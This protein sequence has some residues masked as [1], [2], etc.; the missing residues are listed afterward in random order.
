M[1]IC[2]LLL[3][4]HIYIFT[5]DFRFLLQNYFTHFNITLQR[6]GQ[7]VNCYIY[8]FYWCDRLVTFLQ[9]GLSLGGRSV[10]V[11]RWV[12]SVGLDGRATVKVAKC[13]RHAAPLIAVCLVIAYVQR[14]GKIW[15]LVVR[16][17]TWSQFSVGLPSD[18]TCA[19]FYYVN[20]N[21]IYICII[22]GLGSAQYKVNYWTLPCVNH[23]SHHNYNR[24]IN[25]N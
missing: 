14:A 9:T 1:Y 10:A 4:R 25:I 15:V 2:C 5:G 16:E 21:D 19:I 7:P 8:M 17:T 13:T 24:E 12:S 20:R 23:P 6:V 3:D 11:T 18:W 22:N